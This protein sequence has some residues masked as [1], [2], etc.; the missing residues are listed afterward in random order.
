MYRDPNSE[1]AIK[2]GPA[3]ML[4]LSFVAATATYYFL[5]QRIQYSTNKRTVLTLSLLMGGTSICS[6]FVMKM[7]N[8]AS[9][10]YV[11]AS[12]IISPIVL[13]VHNSSSCSPGLA[14]PT[15]DSVRAAVEDWVFS[16]SRYNTPVNAHFISPNIQSYMLN[17]NLSLPVVM[18]TGDSHANML[19]H[20]F[21]KIY[22]TIGF[23]VTFFHYSLDGYS[24][25]ILLPCHPL[26]NEVIQMIKRIQPRKVLWSAAWRRWLTGEN[27]SSL[28]TCCPD[29]V[30][31]KCGPNYMYTNK[32]SMLEK[33]KQTWIELNA[34]GIEV[35]VAGV[36]PEGEQFI[37]EKMLDAFGNIIA[38]NIQ[39]V[40]LAHYRSKNWPLISQLEESIAAANASLMD[41]SINQCCNDTCQ[42]LDPYG[43]PIMKDHS[44]FRPFMAENYLDCLDDLLSL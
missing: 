9:A 29:N 28:E 6:F 1:N 3:L 42:V 41:Y 31:E 30:F 36:N 37:P 17:E 19:S 21:N 5:E 16:P 12:I 25:P 10:L 2:L 18:L 38:K 39:P 43:N 13:T 11:D 34:M 27:Q 14:V 4:L 40:S 8:V 44:H 24:G 15:V 26:F 32:T 35:I 7:P 20:R 22:S 23:N 33:L